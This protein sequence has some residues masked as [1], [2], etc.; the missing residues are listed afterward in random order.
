[1]LNELD[2]IGRRGLFEL[3]TASGDGNFVGY[4]EV[5]DLQIKVIVDS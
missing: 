4:Q 5:Y 3:D 1:M 2:D